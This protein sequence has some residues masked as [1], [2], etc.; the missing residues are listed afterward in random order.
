M[1]TFNGFV[2]C[3]MCECVCHCVVFYFEWKY[4]WK[5]WK[6]RKIIIPVNEIDHN[7]QTTWWKIS[8]FICYH[9]RRWKSLESRISIY[10]NT[11]QSQCERSLKLCL[12]NLITINIKLS[13]H[14]FIVWHK[15]SSTIVS[16][17]ITIIHKCNTLE[18]IEILTKLELI[19]SDKIF[20]PI[21]AMHDCPLDFQRS[22]V[23]TTINRMHW[24]HSKPQTTSL[25][26]FTRIFII[27]TSFDFHLTAFVHTCH[28]KLP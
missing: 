5:K 20:M 27:S 3:Q 23:P 25:T 14:L 10:L 22:L 28:H 26:F 8:T 6:K 21:Y 16:R 19:F 18:R 13:T 15:F 4:A 2:E 12:V 24:I 9:K 7:S 17:V 11:S 1:S